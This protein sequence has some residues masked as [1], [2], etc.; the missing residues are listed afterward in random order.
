MLEEFQCPDKGITRVSDCIAH[1][2]MG[3]RC[4]T[5]PTLAMV[6][7]EREWAGVAS[8]TQLL[9]GTMLEFLKLTKPY[10]IE[11]D[12]RAF[13]IQGTRHHQE[14]E[15]IAKELGLA[16]E[17]ALSGDRDIFDLVEVENGK[18]GMTDYKL[19]GSFK[20]AKALGISKTGQKPDPSGAVYAS[21]SKWG[22]KGSPKMVNTFQIVPEN[23]DNWEAEYQQNRYRVKLE[24]LGVKLDWMQLQVTVRDG[25][26]AVARGRGVERNIYRIPVKKLDNSD[27]ENYFAYKNSNLMQAL[28]QGHWDTICTQAETWEGNRCAEY[29]DVNKYCPQ[30]QLVLKLNNKVG[31][32]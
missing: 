21:T 15:S 10:C 30:G 24:K 1:C 8:T 16:S 22:V 19:W 11:P 25:G 26:L 5:L 6:S 9:N 14:L 18:I 29:C 27:V 4:M 2:R 31:D 32:E 3:E 7:Q 23:A 17:V 12:S 13:M 20:V 28:A